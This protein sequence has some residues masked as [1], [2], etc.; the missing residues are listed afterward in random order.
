MPIARI[1]V[2]P[3]IPKSKARKGLSVVV[4]GR[5]EGGMEGSVPRASY[6]DKKGYFIWRSSA[7]GALLLCLVPTN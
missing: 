1:R 6:R 4:G 2:E 7:C 3:G 5:R